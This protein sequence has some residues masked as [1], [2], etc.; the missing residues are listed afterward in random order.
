MSV[1]LLAMNKSAAAAS[2]EYDGLIGW[3]LGLMETL[4]A[5]G[6]G[7]AV[8]IETFVPPIPS[9]AVLPGAGFLAFE[10]R[11][12]AVWA[13]AAATLGALLGAWAWYAIGAA[14]GR[15]RVRRLVGGVPLMDVEDFDRAESFFT[16][17]G[18]VA[19]FVGRCV[20]LVRSF[21]SI[22]AGVARMPLWKFT[23]YT[24]LGSGLWNG[25][26]IGLGFA[27]GPAIRPILEQWSGL[28][29]DIVVV[30]IIALVAWFAA[31]RIYRRIRER[32]ADSV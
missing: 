5:V 2:N 17:W 29:S 11:M 15:D 10:G 22:P 13:W 3:V 14:L 28:L 4:G 32:R 1:P 27:F 7:L 21:V 26:W 12:S 6:V 8:L 25:V 16:R 30:A 9:E 24:L 23:A 20:P 19:V 18:G 31:T